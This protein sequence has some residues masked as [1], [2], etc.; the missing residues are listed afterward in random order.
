M[1]P[2]PPFHDR[3]SRDQSPPTLDPASL[4][5]A[6]ADLTAGDPDL[7]RVVSQ[8]GPPPLWAREPGFAT[9][10]HIILEQ[11]VSLASARAVLDR[12]QAAAG[13]LTPERLLAF[14]DAELRAFG[15]SRQKARYCRELA[16]TVGEGALDLAEL[17]HLEDDAVRDRLTRIT[18]IGPWTADVY[19]LMALRRPDVWPVGDLALAVAA[20]AVKGLPERPGPEALARLGQP[21]RPWRAVAARILWHYYLSGA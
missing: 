21:W 15:F 8:F 18:G 9:L 19:L 7:A 12:L 16:R 14:S 11:Q 4:A 5:R 6:V 3:G 1:P 20:Q 10:V 17:V 13:R 2:E